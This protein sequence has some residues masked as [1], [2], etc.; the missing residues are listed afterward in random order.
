MIN[1][2]NDNTALWIRRPHPKYYLLGCSNYSNS[3]FSS[4]VK[5]Q[6]DANSNCILTSKHKGGSSLFNRLVSFARDGR[7]SRFHN[8]DELSVA[9]KAWIANS[10][11]ARL[12][13]THISTWNVSDVTDMSFLF[14]EEETFNEDISSWNVG[15][16]T[17]MTSMFDG[18]RSFN[19][20]IGNWNVSN[21]TDMSCMFNE[22]E[23][24]DQDI[25][26]WNVSNVTDM[27]SMFDS[28]ISFDQDISR[29]NV[30]SVTNMSYM[31]YRA[32]SFN[33][34]IGG[35]NVSN[36]TNMD[37]MF[38]FADSFQPRHIRNRWNINRNESKMMY[39]EELGERL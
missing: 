15:N 13:Y 18:A 28:A 6:D 30:S 36:V 17:S 38:S 24:F 8:K 23:S 25:G 16:V 14:Y 31:F 1:S 19:Q 10:I 5:S 7:I 29:W 2:N 3:N 20:N 12:T 21:V 26:N 35:W 37:Y 9:V 27:N 4:T 34:D 39:H 33:Q 11:T 22:A 32:V